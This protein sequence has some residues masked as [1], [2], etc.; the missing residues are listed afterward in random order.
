VK[1]YYTTTS[2]FARK[3]RVVIKEAGLDNEV[4]LVKTVVRNPQSSLLPLSPP[5]KVPVLETLDGIIISEANY[6]C[7]YLEDNFENVQLLPGGAR[8][9]PALA[10]EGLACGLLEGTATWVRAMRAPEP[11]RNPKAVALEDGRVNR[12]LDAFEALAGDW[13]EPDTPFY[14]PRITLSCALGA[15]S[16][17]MPQFDWHKNRPSLSAWWD[18][19]SAKSS[20]I[21][22][23]PFE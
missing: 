3:V 17:R 5:G 21:E 10:M 20:L 4:T 14:L 9:M 16:F 23:M 8:R 2:P 11:I 19:I 13:N 22:T 12:C 1:L 6:I 7:A 15:L 18:R